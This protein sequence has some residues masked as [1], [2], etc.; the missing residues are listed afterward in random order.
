MSCFA[1]IRCVALR[2]QDCAPLGSQSPIS[3]DRD[4][5]DK[6]FVPD[7][8]FALSLHHTTLIAISHM[9]IIIP[10]LLRVVTVLVSL[11]DT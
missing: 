7:D 10:L 2:Y 5:L 11:L 3:D 8:E 9:P 6:V 4:F 1:T